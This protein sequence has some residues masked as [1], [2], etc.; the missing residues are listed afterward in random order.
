MAP[1][2]S[3]YDAAYFCTITSLTRNNNARTV[4]VSLTVV[5]DMSLGPLQR[6]GASELCANRIKVPLQSETVLE[7]TPLCIRAELVYLCPSELVGMPL[8]FTFGE[9][10]YSTV[11]CDGL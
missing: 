1:L 4:T 3:R 9:G 6:P 8:T 2:I 11:Q 5:G 7:D 10:G